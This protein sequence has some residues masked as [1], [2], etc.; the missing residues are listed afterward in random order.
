MLAGISSDCG[1]N[2]LLRSLGKPLLL[3]LLTIPV[4]SVVSVGKRSRK[5]SKNEFILAPVD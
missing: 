3:S 5:N 2:I 1:L 4:K